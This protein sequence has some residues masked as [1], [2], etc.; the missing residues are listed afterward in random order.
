MQM[1]T[2]C[3]CIHKKAACSTKSYRYLIDVWLKSTGQIDK[4]HDLQ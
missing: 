2:A 1:F 4:L 3:T